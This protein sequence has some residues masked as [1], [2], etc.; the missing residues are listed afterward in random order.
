MLSWRE[1]MPRSCTLCEHPRREEIDRALVG[2]SSNLSVSSLFGVSE[3]AIRRHKA[4]HLPAKLVMA[5]AA[6]EVAQADDLLDQ[7]RDLQARTLAI[8]EAAESTRQHRTALAAIR[9]ARSNLELLAKLLGELD[10]R[11][12]VNLNVSPEWLE[13]RAVIV[14]ALEPYSD[15]RGAVL[16]AIESVNNGHASG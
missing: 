6:E 11:P 14:A 3:S 15:A 2:D 12:V 7:V 13:L 5:Q 4:N 10:E 1:T 9:E 16:R 8:L